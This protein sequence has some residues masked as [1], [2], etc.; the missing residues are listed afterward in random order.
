MRHQ[1]YGT[2]FQ[3]I[4]EIALSL[5]NLNVLFD[6]GTET[7]KLHYENMSVQYAAISKSGKNDNF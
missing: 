5:I 3:V 1:C 2:D 7:M 6:H 4:L